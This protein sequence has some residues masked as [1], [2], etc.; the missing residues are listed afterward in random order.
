MYRHNDTAFR[1]QIPMY[2]SARDFI[3]E[4]GIKSVLD[5]GCGNPQ[6]LKAYILPFVNDIIG[7]DLPEVVNRI[8]ESFGDWIGMDLDNDSIHLDKVFG[9]IIAADVI[10]HLKNPSKMLDLIKDHANGDTVILVSTPERIVSKD[11]EK[12]NPNNESHEVEYT[13]DEMVRTLKKGGLSVE[14]VKS[15]IEKNTPYRY[16]SNMFLCKKEPV[17]GHL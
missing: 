14:G 9:L 15:Y 10:E 2:I 7:L 11:G 16:L 6:K 13:K 4:L 12:A 5:V 8:E 17:D 3:V 1:F